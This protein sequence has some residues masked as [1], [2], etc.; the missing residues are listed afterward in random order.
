[1]SR[2]VPFP[3]V[4]GRSCCVLCYM[5]PPRLQIWSTFRLLPVFLARNRHRFSSSNAS[6]HYSQ[7]W[8]HTLLLQDLLLL[9][10][11]NKNVST[12]GK[13][14]WDCSALWAKYILS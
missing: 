3:I 6:V 4:P 7:N 14:H 2:R 1:M 5:E 8:L 11:T 13:Q 12:C 10:H 9:C